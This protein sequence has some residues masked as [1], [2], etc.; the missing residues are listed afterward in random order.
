MATHHD[1]GDAGQRQ[2]V[3]DCFV[4]G[5]IAGAEQ[6][7]LSAD[8]HADH[9]HALLH[10]LGQHS[11]NEREAVHVGRVQGHQHGVEGEA[12]HRFE[13]DGGMVMSRQA[14]EADALFLACPD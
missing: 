9:A 14:E 13:E 3:A 10:G 11:L 5:Q 7:A 4:H 8:L 2:H 12:A 1:G 6:S